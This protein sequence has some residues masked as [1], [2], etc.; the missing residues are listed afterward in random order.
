M[1]LCTLYQWKYRKLPGYKATD[2]SGKVDYWQKVPHMDFDN[3]NEDRFLLHKTGWPKTRSSKGPCESWMEVQ[4]FWFW[5]RPQRKDWGYFFTSSCV[6]SHYIFRQT[7][8]AMSKCDFVVQDTPGSIHA[9]WAAESHLR[10]TRNRSGTS[11]V[12]YLDLR[13]YFTLKAA[14]SQHGAG[15]KP[16]DLTSIHKS[17]GP[18]VSI[19]L[20]EEQ[21]KGLWHQQAVISQAFF[22]GAFYSILQQIDPSS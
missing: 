16:R 17:C 22:I 3:N 4:L 9:R 19:D 21:R 18:F 11:I 2:A 15:I 1:A 7:R 5:Q 12:F 14:H 8:S 20:C 10:K 13:G 6:G